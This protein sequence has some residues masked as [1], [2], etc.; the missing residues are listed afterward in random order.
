M[1]LHVVGREAWHTALIWRGHSLSLYIC[2]MSIIAS[3]GMGTNFLFFG[4]GGGGAYEP[5]TN[6]PI[7]T[8]RRFARHREEFVLASQILEGGKHVPPSSSYT[9]GYHVAL[10]VTAMLVLHIG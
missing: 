4:G 9:Y 8:I 2:S 7:G 5:K 1:S 3:V 10:S 6:T